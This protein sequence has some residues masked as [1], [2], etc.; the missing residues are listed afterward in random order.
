LVN[1]AFQ[2]VNAV[3]NSNIIKTPDFVLMAKPIKKGSLGAFFVS[4]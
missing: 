3:G 4:W 2:L 1:E